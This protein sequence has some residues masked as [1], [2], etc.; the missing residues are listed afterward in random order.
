MAKHMEVLCKLD[1]VNGRRG[2]VPG[3]VGG[4]VKEGVCPPGHDGVRIPQPLKFGKVSLLWDARKT[5]TLAS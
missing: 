2:T 1:V 5:S 3:A 4:S